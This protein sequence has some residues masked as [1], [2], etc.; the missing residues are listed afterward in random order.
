MRPV[1]LLTGLIVVAACSPDLVRPETGLDLEVAG[2]GAAVEAGRAFPL[3]MR[4][5]WTEGLEDPVLDE[6]T[7]GPLVLRL[8]ERHEA[9]DGDVHQEE[10]R[11]R[12]YAFEPG[13][14]RIQPSI[15]A[16]SGDG[17]QVAQAAAFDL[18]VTAAL[19]EG[20]DSAVEL[21]GAPLEPPVPQRW[22]W[23]VAIGVAVLASLLGLRSMI[24]RFL[25]ALRQ[26]P[27][28][29]GVQ[30]YF[31]AED[32]LRALSD[33]DRGDAAGTAAFYVEATDLIR[34]YL[35]ER[36]SLPAPERTSEE[37]LLDPRTQRDLTEPVARRLD[38]LLH[39]ADRVKFGR[40]G[41]VEPDC[42]A[43]ITAATAILEAT[44]PRGARAGRRP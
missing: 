30:G 7:L 32:R 28:P 38:R 3:V 10:R 39:H 33:L 42:Q 2:P 41:T 8:E 27:A 4:W 22:P 9:E 25:M 34:D 6:T 14:H 29:R 1:L 20:D 24:R 19:P 37:L 23:F 16:V 40:P 26:R 21:P 35:A 43:V 31:R 18:D 11:Y 13:S 44:R 12:A 5:R 17:L 15:R 36:F